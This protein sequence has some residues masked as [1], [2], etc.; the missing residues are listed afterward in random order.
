MRKR[1]RLHGHSA[2]HY[3]DQLVHLNLR[4]SSSGSAKGVSR[5]VTALLHQLHHLANAK[6]VIQLLQAAP[7]NF[8]A[9]D[10]KQR[11]PLE[12]FWPSGSVS[13]FMEKWSV[14]RAYHRI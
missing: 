8:C 11:L 13:S 4:A 5:V 10:R 3:G 9:E 2:Q 6:H 7:D 14:D 12:P 1:F